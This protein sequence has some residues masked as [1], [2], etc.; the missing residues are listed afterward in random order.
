MLERDD[1]TNRYKAET[2]ISIH[3]F[4]YPLAQGMDSVHLNA[5]IE[6]GG[7]DQKFNLL[8]GR[9]LQREY[10][11]VPQV[12]ITL[13]LLE[14]TDGI[15]KMSKSYGN[16]ISFIDLPKDM[17]GKSMSIP[18]YYFVYLIRG[19]PLLLQL[20]FVY[21]GLGQFSFIRESILWPILKEP[22]WCAIIAFRIY[23]KETFYTDSL[24][25]N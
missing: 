20:Y 14:G 5:D 8:V 22:Y 11:Q 25:I 3:E 13:P 18:A 17:Y 23:F 24:A 4:M 6:L 16:D 21:Y 7:T 9:D 10:N 1:F 15:E 12:I 19:T 2:P